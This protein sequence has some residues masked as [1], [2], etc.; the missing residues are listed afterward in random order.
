MSGFLPPVVQELRLSAKEAIHEWQS[1]ATKTERALVQAAA[2][3]EAEATRMEASAA[4]AALEADRLAER[5]S[6]ETGKTAQRAQLAAKHAA[7]DA[8]IAGDE[9]AAAR[10]KATEAAAAAEA[11]A[12]KSAAAL[13]KLKSAANTALIGTSVAL[14]GVGYE[15]V[16]MAT[17][18][19][20]SVNLLVTGAGESRKNI[21]LVSKGLLEMAGEVGISADDLAKGMYLVES[22]G[23]H[24]AHGLD[25]MRA[26]AQ[27]AKTDGADAAEVADALTTVLT[28]MGSHAEKPAMMMSKMVAAV[29]AGK[30]RM[31][32][33]AGSIHSVLPNATA[34]GIS[35]D[36]VAGAL[37]T[38]TAQ[39]ISAD[40]AAQNL[41]HVLVSM[42]N[43][44]AVQTKAMAAYGLSALDVAKNLGKRGLTGTLDLLYGAVMRQS[45]GGL[46]MQSAFMANKVAAEGLVTM[47]SKLPPEV[48]KLADA[49]THGTINSRQYTMETRKMPQ[50]QAVLARQ[51]RTASDNAKGFSQALRSGKGD[52]QTMTGALAQM[53]GGQTGLQVAMHLSG[54]NMETFKKN[55]EKVAGTTSAADGS[56]KDFE[57]T[58]Q[59]LAQKLSQAKA[60]AGAMAIEIGTVLIPPISAALGWFQKHTTATKI[61]G[62]SLLGIVGT[63]ALLGAALKVFAMAQGIMEMAKAV[64]AFEIGAK[65]ASA[66]TKVWAVAQWALSAAMNA[67]PIGLIVIAV[68]ALVAGIIYAYTH[69]E[70][71]RNVVNA[72]G[73]ALKG[74][75]LA[76]VRA[77]VAAWHWLVNAFQV[78]V[79]W[80]QQLPRRILAALQAFPGLLFNMFK[81]GLEKLFWL[82]G[83]SIGL[84]VNLFV[85]LPGWIMSGVSGLWGLLTGFFT[86]LWNWMVS[87]A[88]DVLTKM[89]V[90]SAQLVRGIVQWVTLLPGRVGSFFYQMYSRARKEFF[91][92]LTT[93]VQMA[94]QMV[95]G[96]VGWFRRLPSR[97][98][99]EAGKLPGQIRSVFSRAGSWL[100]GAGK[101]I[102]QGL[103]NGLKAAAGAALGAVEDLGGSLLDGFRSA[104]RI[105]SPS[106]VFAEAGQW[107]PAGIAQG[108]T[109]GMPAVHDALGGVPT[110]LSGS[111]SLSGTGRFGVTGTGAGRG[112]GAASTGEV[113]VP[114]TVTVDGQVLYR[115]VQRVALQYN[116]RNL[117]NGLALT[118]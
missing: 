77:T 116:R 3:A 24:G 94:S 63:L 39:G 102:V 100:Y 12:T 58:Q 96:V 55:V 49:Y 88:K 114:V 16:K 68:A 109:Q 66:A 22:A 28:D 98:A 99:A 57:E 36:Q 92:L 40:Q 60:A 82:I 75:F 79:S 105:G 21:D 73:G 80:F 11:G 87:T 6:I 86:N 17:E 19:Q 112:G 23:F 18:F 37:A 71:F 67:N 46:A 74:A 78:S 29:G 50:A 53:T 7:D 81:V 97:A 25:V 34:L 38:M 115:A 10:V 106:K 64:K 65:L 15:S 61:M 117:T 72:V 84:I 48:K 45:S 76:S 107:I 83:F 9:A 44:T 26:A 27:G 32:D 52:L 59:N 2:T 14:A 5:A 43:P 104:M 110:N 89:I 1:Y 118:I 33:F 108:I 113:L 30:M 85:H 62:A 20:K 103:V 51:F 54:E 4:R 47:Y 91:S 93:A 41:N 13:T 90:W 111:Y 56:V 8:R 42:A 35:F 95:N 70:G 101:A 31:S 69:F